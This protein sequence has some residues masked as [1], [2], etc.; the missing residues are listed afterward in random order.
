VTVGKDIVEAFV[1]ANYME[2][3]AY[4]Q[5]MALQI[6]KPYV[7]SEEEIAPMPR[8]ALE[9]E[10]L[11]AHLGPLPGEARL[12]WPASGSPSESK[13]KDRPRGLSPSVQMLAARAT[14]SRRRR[15]R[16][17]RGTA[18]QTVSA[19]ERALAAGS[20]NLV[21]APFT[22]DKSVRWPHRGRDPSIPPAGY[23]RG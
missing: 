2:K 11:H 17:G 7:F 9:R 15:K 12:S 21:R 14:E 23:T 22:R 1:L 20:N 8:E 10:P 16:S 5:Y 18:R 4:R 6:G 19:A 13:Q 3:N